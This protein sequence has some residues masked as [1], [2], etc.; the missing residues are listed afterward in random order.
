[1][2]ANAVYMPRGSLR[3][4][5]DA[6]SNAYTMQL[7]EDVI[8]KQVDSSGQASHMMHAA[9]CWDIDKTYW[10]NFHQRKSVI[11]ELAQLRKFTAFVAS[12]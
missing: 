11:T 3:V 7:T 10:I 6:S 12:I 8:N 1:M 2:Q 9:G 4:V 5:Y